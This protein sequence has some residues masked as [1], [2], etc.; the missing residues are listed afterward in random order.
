M[1]PL[2][3][4]ASYLAYPDSNALATKKCRR[5]KMLCIWK[6]WLTWTQNDY[7]EYIQILIHINVGIFEENRQ[8]FRDKDT[9]K[10]RL[11]S[12]SVFQ[13]MLSFTKFINKSIRRQQYELL[14]LSAISDNYDVKWKCWVQPD[15]SSLNALLKSLTPA[16]TTQKLLF[17]HSHL[18]GFLLVPVH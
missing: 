18:Q 17:E 3:A 6:I 16:V 14:E 2:V 11:S 10:S 4:Q 1:L 15:V 5:L 9:L 12:N 7:T 8:N 13:Q